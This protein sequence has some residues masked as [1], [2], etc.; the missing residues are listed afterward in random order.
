MPM[1]DALHPLLPIW[2]IYFQPLGFN[3]STGASRPPNGGFFKLSSLEQQRLNRPR[4]ARENIKPKLLITQQGQWGHYM[5]LSYSWGDGVRHP[6]KLKG[7]KKYRDRNEDNLEEFL[8]AIPDGEEM[9]LTHREALR[10]A[11]LLGYG[12][13]WIDALCIIQG[14]EDDW[15][16]EVP[17]LPQVYGNADFT[18]VAGRSNYSPNG[19][20][21]DPYTP[22][23]RP[24]RLPYRISPYL[25]GA[26]STSPE[27]DNYYVS[28][29]RS[30]ETGPVSQRAW[31]FQEAVLSR[32][33]IVYGTE[34]LRFECR[35]RRV[36]EDGRFLYTK[37][38]PCLDL[39]ISMTAS[40]LPGDPTT[41]ELLRDWYIRMIDYS[42][43]DVFD[44]ED[45]FTTTAGT[46]AR[47]QR[48]LGGSRYPAGLWEADMISG[49][50]WFGRHVVQA[51]YS[52]KPLR[53]PIGVRDANKAQVIERAP[54]W[55]CLAL[56][57]PICDEWSTRHLRY[58]ESLCR[59]QVTGRLCQ[60]RCSA[61]IRELRL[62]EKLRAM[63]YPLIRR[64]GVV[65]EPNGPSG[66]M[67]ISNDVVDT[68]DADAFRIVALGIFDLTEGNT[69]RQ[70]A[71]RLKEREGLLL[72]KAAEPNTFKR[73][74]VFVVK[75]IE[76]FESG[77]EVDIELA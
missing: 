69:H 42:R 31:C 35:E 76:F 12:Y 41:K 58:G 19:F 2:Y 27:N 55:S 43:L 17:R 37:G 65:L 60:L 4:T 30:L 34:Q 22:E 36:W 44:P 13:I 67:R 15:Q 21:R 70:W 11:R 63:G 61:A 49:L 28:L 1:S 62:C 72:E 9:T 52:K 53:R 18:L 54:S 5:T 46:A 10:I 23:V 40:G 50:L 77:D 48:A 8:R 32:R 75:D 56:Q 7:G 51:S 68:K 73:V 24:C 45:N 26:L 29:P 59:L 57:G 39:S 33:Q 20:V 66:S 25:P 74:G 47:F 16:K 38:R 6:I 14:D 71:M 3:S 64:R